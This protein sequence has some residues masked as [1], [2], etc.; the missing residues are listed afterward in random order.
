MVRVHETGH[1]LTNREI[2]G[3]VGVCGRGA[4]LQESSGSH[5]P[6]DEACDKLYKISLNSFN[7]RR[8]DELSFADRNRLG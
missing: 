7:N 1:I 4:A 5:S 8:E 2:Q 6:Q 3:S